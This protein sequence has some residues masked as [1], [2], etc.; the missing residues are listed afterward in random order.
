MLLKIQ[1]KT[2]RESYKESYN[3][4]NLNKILNIISLNH[5]QIALI[6]IKVRLTKSEVNYILSSSL[7]FFD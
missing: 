2:N 4:K 3:F 7:I 5:N 6:I 1:T